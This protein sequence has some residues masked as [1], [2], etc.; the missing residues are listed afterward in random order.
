[1]LSLAD[2]L[3]LLSWR[4]AAIAGLTDHGTAIA[5]RAP[6]NLCVIDPQL[7]WEVDPTRFASRAR[8]TPFGGRTLT[9]RV[10]HTILRG[11][12]VVV[13]GVACR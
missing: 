1:V 2:A 12:P 6:A 11:E 7:R 4:P 9:G 3:A 10:R 13:D 5:A 8:N